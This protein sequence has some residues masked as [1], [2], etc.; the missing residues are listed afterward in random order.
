MKRILVQEAD[1]GLR[2]TLVEIARSAGYAAEGLASVGELLARARQVRVDGVMA[3]AADARGLAVLDRVR[4]ALDSVPVAVLCTEAT[5]GLRLRALERGARAVL[6]W[7]CGVEAVERMLCELTRA[8]S[9]PATTNDWP[10]LVGG[11]P[12]FRRVLDEARSATPTRLTVCLTGEPGTGKASLARAIHR[13]SPRAARPLVEIESEP[14]LRRHALGQALRDAA[15]GSLLI[16]RLHALGSEAQHWLLTHLTETDADAAPRLLCTSAAPLRRVDGFLPPLALRL[17]VVR[18]ALPALRE[19]REDVPSLLA[20]ALAREAETLGLPAP[21][22]AP[23]DAR[24]LSERDWRGNVDE[25]VAL[26]RRAAVLFPGERIRCERWLEAGDAP[27]RSAPPGPTL[28]E[29]ERRTIEQSL[30]A[31]GGNR[32]H[33]SRALGISVRTLRNKIRDYG[34]R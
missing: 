16:R 28:R 18:I 26:C 4:G 20:H 30:A 32:T 33:A 21:Y 7:P 34:L 10:E 14:E 23:E 3:A 11:A 22:L 8:P 9:H 29:V 2:Q 12:A 24:Q 25:L 5:P 6:C 15:E 13:R 31:H 19:R 27:T 17:D 1:T